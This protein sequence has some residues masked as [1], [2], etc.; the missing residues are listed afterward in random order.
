MMATGLFLVIAG[1]NHD[2]DAAQGL[3][4]ILEDLAGNPWGKVAIWIIAFGTFAYGVFA[5]A[6]AKF[7]R[8][9]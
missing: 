4:G 7:R 1:I 3:S 8:S 5:L 2:S 6:E 9:Y